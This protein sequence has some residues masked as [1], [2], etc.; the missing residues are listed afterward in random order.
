MLYQIAIFSIITIALFDFCS[1]FIFIS[2]NFA[3]A[4]IVAL[5]LFALFFV[6]RVCTLDYV[7][8]YVLLPVWLSLSNCDSKSCRSC[9]LLKAIA[10]SNGNLFSIISKSGK[11]RQLLK[12][13]NFRESNKVKKQRRWRLSLREKSNIGIAIWEKSKIIW[14]FG[15]TNIIFADCKY[16]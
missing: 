8:F 2:S 16:M 4:K 11:E 10:N 9:T 7:F 12:I 13:D 1:T 5:N 15:C 6:S 3:K 14:D